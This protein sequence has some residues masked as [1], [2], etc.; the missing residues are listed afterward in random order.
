MNG[1]FGAACVEIRKLRRFFGRVTRALGK[2][3]AIVQAACGPVIYDA[4]QYEGLQAS[5][6]PLGFVKPRDQYSE[7][8]EFRF[9]WTVKHAPPLKPFLL[10]VPEIISLC[11]R[12]A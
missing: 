4:R 3:H 12:V 6:G 11:T 9:L 10:H 1:A 8:R 5:P 2:E 7:Q